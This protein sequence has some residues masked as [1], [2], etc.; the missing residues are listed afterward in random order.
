SEGALPSGSNDQQF[1]AFQNFCDSLVITTKVNS[2]AN[3]GFAGIAFR[4]SEAPGSRMVA[5]K[6]KK[7]KYVYR[8]V[9]NTNNGPKNT[10]QFF[11]TGHKWLRMVRNGN[12]FIGYSSSDG[13]NWLQHFSINL[14]MPS[15]IDAGLF[16][17]STHPDSLA[18]GAFSNVSMLSSTSTVITPGGDVPTGDLPTGEG[19]SGYV[20]YPN[21]TQ[22]LINVE[23]DNTFLGKALTI[24][25][26]NQ[27]GQMM[28]IRKIDEVQDP[29]ET[30]NVQ[31]LPPGV[32]IMTLRTDGREAFAKK[33]VVVR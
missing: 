26:N 19:T 33:F 6:L 2:I 22:A 15:C 16:V 13:V 3:G 5:L 25:I 10:Q 31:Y 7:G 1:F 8:E 30:F 32:Y 11:T 29:I 28:A 14:T 24:A 17:E 23:M 9:R 21:P 27:F 12:S 4:E 18:V 20:I